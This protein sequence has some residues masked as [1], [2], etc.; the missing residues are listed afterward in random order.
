VRSGCLMPAL[1]T[2]TP[3]SPAEPSRGP[4]PRCPRAC[5]PRAPSRSAT[6]SSAG[7][8]TC[9]AASSQPPAVTDVVIV[10]AGL[11]GLT[12]AQD[13]TRAGIECL[14]L[15]ASDGRG[16]A[17]GRIPWTAFC[18]IAAFRS[19]SPPTRRCSAGSISMRSVSPG[20][21]RAQSFAVT[22]AC[23]V[24]ATRCVAPRKHHGRLP[25]RSPRSPTSCGRRGC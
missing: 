23:T 14:M 2:A 7:R 4:L 16:G 1:R 21:S 8:P 24:G 20:L 3:A 18:W 15:E 12:C 6:H 19:C 9:R 5:P 22:G 13:L 17:C 10:G 11:A 25:P